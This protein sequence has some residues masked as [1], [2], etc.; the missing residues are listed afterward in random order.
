MRLPLRVPKSVGLKQKIVEKYTFL[1]KEYR[2][3]YPERKDYTYQQLRNNISQVASIVNSEIESSDVH[4]STFIP[5]L[6]NDWKQFYY[7]H[8]YFAITIED[9]SGTLTAVVQDAHY[10]GDHHNDTLLSKPYDIE[11]LQYKTY[12]D[13]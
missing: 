13:T 9:L 1:Y 12:I 3:F 6:D 4:T 10:E 7:K 8:W 5:W 2:K 11:D